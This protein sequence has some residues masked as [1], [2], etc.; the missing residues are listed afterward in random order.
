M[1]PKGGKI[2]KGHQTIN[3][4]VDR[5][6]LEVYDVLDMPRPDSPVGVTIPLLGRVVAGK[7]IPL[8]PCE[9]S[10]FDPE[11]KITILR[12]WLPKNITNTELLFALE[13][14]GESMKEVLIN[15]G[16]TIVLAKS[17]TAQN[18]DIVA[19]RID[20]EDSVTLKRFYRENGHIRLQPANGS[21]E[22]II[23]DANKVHVEG[24]VVLSIRRW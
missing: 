24:K 7:P 20:D 18:G 3:K 1:K 6:G 23:V 17:E 12:E 16:D 22:P 21:M 13:V 19:V 11:S 4:L 9:G 14:E 5:F 2:P 8:P 10:Y 15:N